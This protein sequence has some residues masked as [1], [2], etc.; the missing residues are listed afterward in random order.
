MSN[1]PWIFKN[2]MAGMNIPHLKRLFPNAKF[3]FNRRNTFDNADSMLKVRVSLYGDQYSWWSVK[4]SNYNE[5]IKIKDPYQQV[6]A[7]V[8][9]IN[10]QIEQDL[11]KLDGSD[12]Y[13]I[14]YEELCQSPHQ[15]LDE[16]PF[17]KDR[18]IKF[19]LPNS[20]LNN[21]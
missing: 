18:P 2:L 13:C 9:S 6:I 15:V 12:F 10:Q 11:E 16:I 14:S 21:S 3:I 7:Q 17:L 20:F 19:E 5:I 1:K 8:E 4:P